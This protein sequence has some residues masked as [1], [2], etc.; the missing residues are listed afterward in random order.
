MLCLCS[1]SG[2]TQDESVGERF[3]PARARAADSATSGRYTEVRGRRKSKSVGC[4]TAD[5]GGLCGMV[6]KDG[7][8]GESGEFFHPKEWKAVHSRG[9]DTASPPLRVIIA[10][11]LFWS[12]PRG[13]KRTEPSTKHT[14][15]PGLWE[16]S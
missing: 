6:E 5:Q 10:R 7:A 11:S 4:V 3:P 15:V 9:K 13:K 14:T 16:T 12:K 1:T 2:T 8:G